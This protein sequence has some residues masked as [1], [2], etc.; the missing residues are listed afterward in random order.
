MIRSIKNFI[1][2]MKLKKIRKEIERKYIQS[3]EYQRN[4]KLKEYAQ[5]LTEVKLL[6]E[7]Y[8]LANKEID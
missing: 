5:A 6:E 2:Q 4:G 1:A 3:V 7:K 8:E